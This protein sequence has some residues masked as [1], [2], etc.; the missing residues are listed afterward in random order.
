[1]SDSR[2]WCELRGCNIWCSGPR[3][4]RTTA[5]LFS[6]WI[7]LCFI[8]ISILSCECWETF[9]VTYKWRNARAREFFLTQSSNSN[10][11]ELCALIFFFHQCLH[12]FLCSFQW[13]QSTFKPVDH[14]QA[15][16]FASHISLEAQARV[17]L[18]SFLLCLVLS[19]RRRTCCLYSSGV[20]VCIP[21]DCVE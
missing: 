3:T 2:L 13:P 16:V 21:T 9:S 8:C 11:Q 19:R 17:C 10:C 7:S 1:M 18:F 5:G 4:S 14:Q 20:C 6:F 15:L 12:L